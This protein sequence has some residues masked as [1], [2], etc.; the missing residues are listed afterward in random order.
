MLA[1]GLMLV[2]QL[3]SDLF[4]KT[5]AGWN[6]ISQYEASEDACRVLGMQAQRV[7]LS[8]VNQLQVNYITIINAHR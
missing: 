7:S 8:N 1:L 6:Y 4:S 5:V 3:V 2:S